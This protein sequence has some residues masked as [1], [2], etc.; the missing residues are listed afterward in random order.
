MMHPVDILRRAGACIPLIAAGLLAVVAV[1]LGQQPPLDRDHAAKMTRSAQVFK[2]H[3][4]TVLAEKCLRCHGGKKTEAELDIFSRE[5][6]LKGGTS[7]PA[8]VPGKPKESLL[9][10]LVTHQ[11]EPPMPQGG[12]KLPEDVLKHIEE[13]ISL[14]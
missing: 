2:E 3:V 12:K 8:I 5:S 13:W 1:A 4:R 14:G 6:L 10:K 7:G 11:K 9:F